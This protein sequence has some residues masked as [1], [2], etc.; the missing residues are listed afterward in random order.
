MPRVLIVDDNPSLLKISSIAMR[1]E[2]YDVEVAPDAESGL[3][4]LE[5]TKFDLVLVDQRLPGMA[6]ID[7][8]NEV[9][10]RR[11][12]NTIALMTGAE[13]DEVVNSGFPYLL[14][15]FDYTELVRF[16]NTLCRQSA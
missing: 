13:N 1:K 4:H 3:Q 5:K 14:K 10:R 16:V 15:P 8:I 9:H 7:L 2:G 11:M 6:G 12:C